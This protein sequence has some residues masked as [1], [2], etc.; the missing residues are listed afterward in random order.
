MGTPEHGQIGYLQLPT[1][2]LKASIAFYS[3]VFGWSGEE[4]H[5]SFE[6]PGLIGQWTADVKPGSGPVP[7][8]VVENLYTALMAVT[9]NGG[10][11]SRPPYPDQGDRWLAEITDPAGTPL[12]LVAPN[13]TARSR[14]L[15]A[16]RDVEASSRWYQELVGLTSGHGGAEYEM[17]MADGEIVIQL[18]MRDVEHHHGA[19][20]DPEVPVGNGV[21]VWLGEVSDFDGA[22]ERAGAMG[23]EIVRDTHRNPPA[24]EGPSHREIWLRDPDGYTVVLA[25]PDGEAWGTTGS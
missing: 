24:G 1:T 9:R 3:A 7:W 23:V 14:T 20:V 2:D 6:A 10:T 15:L 19:V 21:L 11:V 18:H 22:V 16:V 17:L 13:R 12:G 4:E 5:G 25:S 8:M